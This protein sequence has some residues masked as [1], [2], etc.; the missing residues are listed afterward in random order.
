LQGPRRP[1]AT[2]EEIAKACDELRRILF[3]DRP[4][5][6]LQDDRLRRAYLG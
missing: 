3:E 6:L 1:H 2:P 5:S 4:Q